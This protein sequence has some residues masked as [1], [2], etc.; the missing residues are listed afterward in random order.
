MEAIENT[1]RRKTRS[2]SGLTRR[3]NRWGYFFV[4]PTI[5]ILLVFRFLPMLSAA[6]LSITKYDLFT[7]PKLI[8]LGNYVALF[9]DQV[10]LQSVRVSAIYVVGSVV[11]VWIVSL[12]LAM[13]TVKAVRFGNAFR[14]VIFIPVVLAPVVVAVL[15][16]FLYFEA[17]MVNT[18][19]GYVGIPS[20]PWLTTPTTAMISIILIGIWRA[21]PYF[22]VIFT[23]GLQAIPIEYYEAGR[24]D[25]T[26]P[27]TEFWHITLPILKPIILL[28]VVISV[29]TALKVFA[30]PQLMTDGGPAGATEVV[31]L[32]IYKTG[33]EFFK[34]GQAS[35]MSILL[36]VVM[37]IFSIAQVRILSEPNR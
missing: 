32:H 36:F 19:L 1:N 3:I 4:L 8:G 29:I 27:W 28:V 7:A 24:I 13:L 30:V 6:Y 9:Q 23:A 12:L 22:M 5:V 25:G 14:T 21:A 11:P 34:M 35:A 17:G 16:R 2:G 33:F 26:N 37:M 10:F 31:P 15:W 18:M 20:V